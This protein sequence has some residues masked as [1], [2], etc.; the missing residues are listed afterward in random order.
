MSIST[1][2]NSG[3]YSKKILLFRLFVFVVLILL[4]SNPLVQA[5]YELSAELVPSDLG[6]NWSFLFADYRA[7]A[8]DDSLIVIGRPYDLG[9]YGSVYI[10]HHEN[11]EWVEKSKLLGTEFGSSAFSYFGAAVAAAGDTVVVGAQRHNL[12]GTVHVFDLDPNTKDVISEVSFTKGVELGD[13]FGLDVDIS[14]DTIVV[15]APFQSDYG[16]A[17]VYTRDST[18]KQW[19][20]EQRLDPAPE[21]NIFGYTVAISGDTILIGDS[22]AD[23]SNGSACL[24][25]RHNDRWYREATLVANPP[26]QYS[27]FG[28]SLAISGDYVFVGAPWEALDGCY[29]AVYVFKN[30]GTTWLEHQKLTC[31]EESEDFRFA[32][33]LAASSDTLVVGSV[34]YQFGMG[35]VYMY[36]LD[37]EG[38]W[39][40]TSERL[41]APESGNE[42]DQFGISV[43]IS[44]NIIIS[45]AP[46]ADPVIDN[47]VV[48]NGGAAYVFAPS[49]LP[50]TARCKD[51]VIVGCTDCIIDVNSN[52]L[53]RIT[54]LASLLDGGSSD[55]EGPLE[56]LSVTMTPPG[57]YPDG[58]YPFGDIM[59]TLTATDEEGLTDSCTRT[60]SV[61][62]LETIL[63]DKLNCSH[64]GIIKMCELPMTIRPSYA[65][66]NKCGTHATIG[67]HRCCVTKD[68]NCEVTLMNTEGTAASFDKVKRG[69]LLEANVT[70]CKDLV[71]FTCD[72]LACTFCID[73]GDCE[74]DADGDE[75][76][77]EQPHVHEETANRHALRGRLLKFV[78]E[79]CPNDWDP[80]MDS[81]SYCPWVA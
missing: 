5:S 80:A 55:T 16:Y 18:T 39:Q 69:D 62:D 10:F 8:I 46:Y 47:T 71:P 66:I 38:D 72:I 60:I 54:N 33:S 40:Y 75:S 37:E 26:Q 36:K 25:R 35:W 31:I 57:Q 32:K 48:S 23:G 68:K 1:A 64:A 41:G 44:N 13:N 30:S 6:P 11:G 70:V 61:Q 21:S 73:D 76:Y 51:N 24:F 42:F 77:Q 67:S 29:G 52:H 74:D 14:G 50:P 56:S 19:Q 59:V 65:Q 15:G 81:F 20:M 7:V 28:I 22:G 2:T 27:N 3:C 45:G 17:Y 53:C 12:V 43:D 9:R 79:T 58:L 63:S 49:N 78:F 4:L 34:G